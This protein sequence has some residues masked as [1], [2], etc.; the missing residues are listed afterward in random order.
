MFSEY[1]ESPELLGYIEHE[2]GV[3]VE[4]LERPLVTG[5]E[6]ERAHTVVRLALPVRYVL[7]HSLVGDRGNM[8]KQFELALSYI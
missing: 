4:T 3:V 8:V 2:A 6:E 5:V 7:K 1:D